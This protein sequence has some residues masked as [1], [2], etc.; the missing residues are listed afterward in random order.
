MWM[1]N[2]RHTHTDATFA[3]TSMY[4]YYV[5][6]LSS[7]PKQC[8]ACTCVVYQVCL[9]LRTMPLFA[10]GEKNQ[11][12]TINIHTSVMG[13]YFG[14]IVN[15]CTHTPACPLALTHLRTQAWASGRGWQDGSRPQ[16]CHPSTSYLSSTLLTTN[17]QSTSPILTASLAFVPMHPLYPVYPMCQHNS[18]QCSSEPILSSSTIPLFVPVL[19]KN[20]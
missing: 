18:T 2:Y 3:R 8:T 5:R 10:G 19:L 12:K 13:S 4:V 1:V 9:P 16:S 20:I 6:V 11:S 15:L 7:V 17:P 14:Q